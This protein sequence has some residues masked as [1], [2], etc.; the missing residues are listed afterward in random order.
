[1]EEAAEAESKFGNAL[2]GVMDRLGPA[3]KQ[4]AALGAATLGIGAAMETVTEA[5]SREASVDV[6]AAQLG[7]TPELAA[8]YGRI[9]GD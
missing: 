5:M 7:A 4:M 1:T 9:A 8:D 3:A 2:N 6:L